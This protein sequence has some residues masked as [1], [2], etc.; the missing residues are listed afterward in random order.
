MPLLYHDSNSLKY[1]P[2]LFL[3][4]VL[5]FPD[6]KRTALSLSSL[7]SGSDADSFGWDPKVSCSLSLF[8]SNPK[9][10]KTYS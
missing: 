10:E 9:K 7:S 6:F 4:P 2:W 5:G 3:V 8:L 1:Q